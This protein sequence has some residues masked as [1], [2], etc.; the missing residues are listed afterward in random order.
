MKLHELLASYKGKELTDSMISAISS[1]VDVVKTSAVEKETAKFKDYDDLK[2][3]LK[4]FRDE[5]TNAEFS[6]NWTKA[7]GKK[8]VDLSAY[9]L[10]KFKGKDGKTNYNELFKEL[11]HLKDT[12]F[13]PGVESKPASEN[14]GTS[15]IFSQITNVTPTP[16]GGNSDGGDGVIVY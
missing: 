10:N 14:S 1:Q 2:T 9:N 15:G 11:P 8:D 16:T 6:E 13:K 3:E 4:T 7:G 12:N 5:K